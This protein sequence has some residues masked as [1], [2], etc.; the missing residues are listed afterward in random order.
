MIGRRSFRVAYAG[1]FLQVRNGVIAL[2][3]VGAVYAVMRLLRTIRAQ[4]A[5]RALPAS[6]GAAVQTP[7]VYR[8]I[9]MGIRARYN[10]EADPAAKR[11]IRH[12]AYELALAYNAADATFDKGSFLDACGISA[13]ESRAHAPEFRAGAEPMPR[14][15][16][17]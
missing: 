3:L 17:D 16:L 8:T 1:S 12:I 10:T 9:A 4:T 7:A 11:A 5:A 15:P 14:S 13:A 6:P 2:V